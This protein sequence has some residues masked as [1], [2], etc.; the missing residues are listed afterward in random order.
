MNQLS[1]H[2][3]P[4]GTLILSGV[5][6]IIGSGWLF[7]AAHAAAIAGPASIFSWIIGAFLALLI[8][9][10]LIEIVSIAPSSM[11]SMG[12]YLRYTHGDFASFIVEW[13]ILL[14]FISL[15]PSEAAASTQYLSNWGY[16]WA[17]TLF[18]NQTHD[19]TTNGLII[20]SLLCVLYFF[21][22]YFSLSILSK[23]IKYITLFKL[24]VP[25]ITL[26]CL[27]YFGHN[28]DN[29][30]AIGNHSIAPYGLNSVVTAVTAGGI[31]YAFNGFSTPISF[32]LE[33]KNPKRNIPIAIFLSIGICALIYIALQYAYLVAIPHDELVKNTWKG[34]NL[35][36]PF[37]NLAIALNLN[38]IAIFMYIDAFVSPSG[39]GIID[40]SLSARVISNL[41]GYFPNQFTKID[42]TTGL[43]KAALWA[44][45]FIAIAIMWL[46]PSWQKIVE[47]VSV[48]FVLSYSL[49]AVC[50]SSFR[51]LS[52][53]LNNNPTA[54][55]I[56]GMRIL[57]PIS[58][59]FATFMLYW[60]RWPYNGLVM[61]V[62][63]LGLPIYIIYA[64]RSKDIN[65]RKDTAQALWLI[66]YL[67]FVAI[68]GYIGSSDFGGVN[69]IP[70][71]YDHI[72]LAIAAIIFYIWGTKASKK[73]EYYIK[74]IEN[75]PKLT[76]L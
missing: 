42:K 2:K 33:A 47:V 19:L 50:N 76:D 17:A 53:N 30:T 67:I 10:N 14:G 28:S 41:S 57:A 62:V 40:M 7:G 38:F 72:I 1:K 43:P 68:F 56:K 55:K 25:L 64:I 23:S 60:S 65:I 8:A 59:I 16:P 5:G 45:L 4:L 12:Q 29:F 69:L 36:S 73:T 21:V 6:T 54:I 58:F 31:V 51:K 61:L 71:I 39:T 24:L 3:I 32:A 9:L 37:A 46:L 44:V 26:I 74:E 70:D 15:V 11:G 48:G 63:L 75:A 18:N 34:L 22:N 27:I 35:S 49:I 52:S 20:A 66:F 13:S